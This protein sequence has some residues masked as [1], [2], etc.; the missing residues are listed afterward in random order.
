MWCSRRLVFHCC[1]WFYAAK[2]IFFLLCLSHATAVVSNISNL[3]RC[4][5]CKWGWE[6]DGGQILHFLQK[7]EIRTGWG[8]QRQDLGIKGAHLLTDSRSSF[9]NGKCNISLHAGMERRR[10]MHKIWT[11]WR[12]LN[13]AQLQKG[14]VTKK[15]FK[16]EEKTFLIG[17]AAVT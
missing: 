17:F 6:C 1:A 14:A 16:K 9:T 13:K 12:S 4:L 15:I 11:G 8:N 7:G 3:F 5:Q 2:N 10:V